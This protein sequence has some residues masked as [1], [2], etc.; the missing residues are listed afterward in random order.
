MHSTSWL[1]LLAV[2][3]YGILHS[4][5]ASLWLKN[6]AQAWFGESVKRWYRLVYNFIGFLSFLPVLA[7]VAWLPDSQYYAI[8]PPWL[9]LSLAG[10]V[11]A[12]LGLV[13][14]ARQ[15]GAWSFL[16]LKQLFAQSS[17]DSQQL[18]VSGLYHYVRHPIYSA[19]IIFIWLTPVMTANIL[20]LNIGLTAYFVIGAW[21]EERKLL[22]EFGDA[23]AEYRK[24]TPMLIPALRRHTSG[25]GKA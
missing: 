17:T 5:L 10:Q 4:L 7:L 2:A 20:L 8:L 19:G 23:Y 9:Y 13:A 21:F 11:L 12:L 14:A 1:I 6:Q 3:L 15:T 18:E 25:V 22:R 16:G 24:R